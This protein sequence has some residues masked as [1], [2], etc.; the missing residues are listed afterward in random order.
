M[1]ATVHIRLFVI[2]AAMAAIAAM[3]FGC[4]TP[5]DDGQTSGPAVDSQLPPD[6]AVHLSQAQ[7]KPTLLVFWAPWCPYCQK[8]LPQL[9][10]AYQTELRQQGRQVVGIAVQ[11]TDEKADEFRQQNGLTFPNIHDQDGAIGQRYGIRGVPTYVFLHGN[12]QIA[13]RSDDT[14]L[15][16]QIFELLEP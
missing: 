13:Y 2:V 15:V 11:T 5:P 12:G 9:Q 16:R 7:G 3:G 4:I 8:E 1:I 6:L 14:D 10:T